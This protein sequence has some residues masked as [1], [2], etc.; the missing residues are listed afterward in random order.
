MLLPTDAL[1]GETGAATPGTA[2]DSSNGTDLL[3]WSPPLLASIR[4]VWLP[5]VAPARL[6]TVRVELPGGV[7]V[8]LDRA[9][10]APLGS[11]LND[12][13]TGSLKATR[14]WPMLMVTSTLSSA[15]H[16]PTVA[17]DTESE[18]GDPSWPSM[19]RTPVLSGSS[20]LFSWVAAVPPVAQDTETRPY[21]SPSLLP[22]AA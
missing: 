8:V 9:P 14:F 21:Q 11:P 20:Q 16:T 12:R 10:L 13:S 22:Q 17:G 2:A 6:E 1:D 4:R 19:S 18:K 7:T 15:A 5:A 3:S